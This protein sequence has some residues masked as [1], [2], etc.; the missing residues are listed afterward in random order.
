MWD[1]KL[2]TEVVL[3]HHAGYTI[4]SLMLQPPR[5]RMKIETIIS[6]SSPVPDSDCPD[7]VESVRFWCT[8]GGKSMQKETTTVSATAEARVATT[9]EGL[10]SIL[11]GADVAPPSTAP[12][13]TANRPT[14]RAL[15]DFAN[16]EATPTE[17]PKAKAKGK[18]RRKPKAVL[19]KR[20]QRLQLN[21]ASPS[22]PR[23]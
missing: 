2:E 15:V 9:Q 13:G 7:D 3:F 16:A 18:P 23:F 19:Q 1:S 20:P 6:K 8:S 17:T 22:V 21:V 11:G 14:I 12:A 5:L 10:A 4:F